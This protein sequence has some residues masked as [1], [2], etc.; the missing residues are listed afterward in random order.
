MGRI[1]LSIYR[2]CAR[3]LAGRG[4]RKFAAVNSLNDWV[5]RKLKTKTAVVD[6]HLMHLDPRDSLDLSVN[7]VYEPFE[8]ELVHQLVG[9]GD[10]VLD[11]GANIGYYTLIFARQVGACGRVFAFEP[12]P[13]NFALLKKN[14]ESNG[15]KNVVLVNAALSD[16]SGRLKLYLCDENRGDH[17]IYPSA[18]NRQAIEIPAITADL[19]VGDQAGD[20]RFVKMDVQGA[21]GRVLLGM[22]RI[23][24]GPGLK[25]VMLEFW[26]QGLRSAG[27]D[28]EQVLDLLKRQEFGFQ[29]ID[30]QRK[31]LST[32]KPES[33]LRDFTME[34]GRQTNLLLS[35]CH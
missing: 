10:K 8:T 13:A 23:L 30:Q 29:I 25:N 1:G 16:Q 21:E 31:Q 18:E 7:E 22:D 9:K 24:Q 2:T 27:N 3:Q 34:N 33:L 17:R 19:C 5:V 6:G 26:P 15:Y 14:V 35:R 4:L 12:D 11:V 32:V 20:I 28:P